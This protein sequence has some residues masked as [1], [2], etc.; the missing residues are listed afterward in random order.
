MSFNQKLFDALHAEPK[1]RYPRGKDLEI[2]WGVAYHTNSHNP[3][4]KKWYYISR[5]V[6]ADG[7]W[8]ELYRHQ[9]GPT[10]NSRAAAREAALALGLDLFHGVFASSTDCSELWG[11]GEMLWSLDR[12]VAP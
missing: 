3:R 9:D 7:K 1:L 6:K 10:G 4:S 8:W 2:G 11:S 12:T 5:L